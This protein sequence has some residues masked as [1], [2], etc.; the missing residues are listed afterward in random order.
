M[1]P[2]T[3]NP[4]AGPSKI[5]RFAPGVGAARKV[6]DPTSFGLLEAPALPVPGDTGLFGL[7]GALV[8]DGDKG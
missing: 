4:G 6:G 7:P 3:F 2:G 5:D 1:A 8:P